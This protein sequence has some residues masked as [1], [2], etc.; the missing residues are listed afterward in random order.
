MLALVLSGATAIPL[1][2]ELN[3]LIRWTGVDHFT[4]YPNSAHDPAW[5]AW[6]L[7][8]R[9]ALDDTHDTFPFL[10][11]G[12][13]WLAFGHFV[14]ALA[15]VGALRDPVRNSWLFDFG[16]LACLLVMP[17]AFVFGAERGIPVWWR[18]IDSSFGVLGLAPLWLC[19]RWAR[20]LQWPSTSD[21]APSRS[22]GADPAAP[23]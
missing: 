17:Y 18:L 9:A 11:Y 15:F 13:D 16:I 1:R 10:F 12:T 21:A 20:R 6:L 19:R 22:A 8:V 2:S 23:I 14:I 4:Q 7:K 5:A 3:W